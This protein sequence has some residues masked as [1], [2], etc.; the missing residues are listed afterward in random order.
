MTANVWNN[1]G[2]SV[3]AL[4]AESAIPLI[5]TTSGY[6]P[7]WDAVDQRLEY[8]LLDTA[9][10]TS[11][12]NTLRAITSRGDWLPATAYGLTDVVRFATTW[13]IAV[14]AHTSSAVFATD[15]ASKWRVYQGVMALDLALGTAAA[16]IGTIHSSPGAVLRTVQSHLDEQVSA[17]NIGLTENCVANLQGLTAVTGARF[18][19]TGFFPGSA[20][21]GGHFTFDA[22]R[23]KSQHNGALVIS[24]TVPWS[25][26]V[27]GL[28]G[29]LAGTGET[30]VGGAGCWIRHT[31]KVKL[32]DFGGIIGTDIDSSVAWAA[33]N[34]YAAINHQ[35]LVLP[36]GIVRVNTPWSIVGAV[37]VFSTIKL[38]GTFKTSATNLGYIPT[39]CGSVIYTSG[40]AAIVATFNDWRNEN[41]D[42]RGVGFVDAS[43]YPAATPNSLLPAISIV[44]GNA[45]GSSGRYITGN[46]LEDVAFN[47]Y[48]NALEFVG[49]ALTNPLL[50]YI[51][52]TSL[53]RTYFSNCGSAILLTD[54]TLNH[55]WISDSVLFQLSSQGIKLTKTGAGTGGTVNATLTNCVLEAMAGL[56]NTAGG[57]LDQRNQL[58]LN[59]CNREFCGLYGAGGPG[60]NGFYSGNPLGYI[61]NTDVYIDGIWTKGLA[62]GELTFPTADTGSVICSAVPATFTVAAGGKIGTPSTINKVD[63]TYTLAAGATLN[64]SVRTDVTGVGFSADIDITAN[65]GFLGRKLLKV[66]GNTGGV[67]YC[68]TTGTFGAGL[69]LTT[70]AGGTTDMVNLVIA[71][72]TAYSLTIR[73][74]CT[75]DGTTKLSP[76]LI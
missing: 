11:I 30:N 68:D 7:V 60:V 2:V 23:P 6:I 58:V 54:C 65:E 34:K 18:F 40:N 66:Y 71:N 26:T 61:A 4:P 49:R 41:F 25:R 44:K 28:A 10:N 24:P 48:A 56:L 70:A 35:E 29:F 53:N 14:E 5:P 47:G 45:D 32:V 73:I 69:T 42:I 43:H 1:D 27:G 52:P 76:Y 74:Q 39:R 13:Y 20:T 57:I 17:K 62:Y 21:G 36:D 3:I 15:T 31:K 50:N 64:R 59:S 9:I 67:K 46:V 33:S 16:G 38:R 19:A 51:G 8:Q 75:T 63:N 55:L 22:T 12:T 72:A 37:D